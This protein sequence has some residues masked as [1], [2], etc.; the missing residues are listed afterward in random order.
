MSSK[1]SELDAATTVDDADEFPSARASDNQKITALQLKNYVAQDGL[2]DGHPALNI[3]S[4]IK[5]G[6]TDIGINPSQN[7]MTANRQY[8]ARLIPAKS[9]TITE[10]GIFLNSSVPGNVTL[11]IYD[12]LDSGIGPKTLLGSVA[13]ATPGVSAYVPG[14]VS[15]P[16]ISGKSYWLSFVSDAAVLTSSAAANLSAT[17]RLGYLSDSVSNNGLWSFYSNLGSYTMTSD[18]TGLTFAVLGVY[19]PVVLWDV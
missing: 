19:C 18:A 3:S 4:L 16:V 5:G 1:I 6:P 10:L 13:I 11:G 8:F 17:G 7:A 12:N 9:V 14:T 15:I 2:S